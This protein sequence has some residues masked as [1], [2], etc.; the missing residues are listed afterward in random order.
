MYKQVT[1]SYEGDDY[2]FVIKESVPNW[3]ARACFNFGR[4]IWKIQDRRIIKKIKRLE[5]AG[6]KGG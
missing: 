5:K 2:T 6:L 3:L 1:M 4:L